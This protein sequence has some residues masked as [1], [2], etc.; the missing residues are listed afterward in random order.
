[1]LDNFVASG[2]IPPIFCSQ[3]IGCFRQTHRLRKGGALVRLRLRGYMLICVVSVLASGTALASKSCDPCQSGCAP[4][5]CAPEM[6]EKTIYVPTYETETHTVTVTQYANETRERTVKVMKRVPETKAVEQTYTVMVPKTETRTVNYTVCKPVFETRTQTY[7]VC[8]PHAETRQGTRV[9]CKVVPTKE[10]RTVCRD[11]GHWEERVI[12][13]Q[14]CGGCGNCGRRRG[15]GSCGGCGSCAP[16]TRT[17]RVWVPNIVQEEVEV[18]VRRVVKESVPCEYTVTVN[19]LEE[20]TRDVKVC[21]MVS[22]Q[23]SREVQCTVCVPEQR[24]RTCNVTTYKCITE[25]V[26]QQY[27]VCVPHQVEKEVQVR[28]CKMVP[29]TILVP[30]SNCGGCSRSCRAPRRCR[31]RCR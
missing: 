24:T 30:A 5:A 23:K 8:V 1:M 27:T 26:E 13:C 21:K 17:C 11:R 25:D 31:R 4:A 15:C 20:R 22:E 9:V 16:A 7:T 14:S 3:P 6:V 19:K 12:A 10:T 29:K 2:T 18:T 28:V